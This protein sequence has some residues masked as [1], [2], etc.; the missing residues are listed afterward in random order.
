VKTAAKKSFTR[1]HVGDEIWKVP[2]GFGV[3]YRRAAEA[4][5]QDVG[6]LAQKLL[7]LIGYTATD[8]QVEN[9]DLYRR[10]EAVVYAATVHAR[11][12]DNPVTRHPRP[13]WL[14]ERPWQGPV[15][16][17]GAFE[18]PTGTPIPVETS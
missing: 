5:P 9:W 12:S 17:K 16:G 15:A 18:G 8:P 3:A 11:A 4:K 6:S 2:R 13:D 7:G 1:I 14:P 10:V